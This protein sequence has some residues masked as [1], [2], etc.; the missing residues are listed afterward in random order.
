MTATDVYSGGDRPELGASFDAVA[1]EYDAARPSYPEALFDAVE[2]LAGR[3]LRGADV[4]D[5]GAGTGIAT[6]LLHARGARVTAV[7]PT[8]GMAAQLHSVSPDI[9]LVR[10]N[11]NALPFRDSSA[12]LITYAQAFHWTDWDRSVPEAVRVLRPGGALAV[13]WNVKD[14]AAGWVQAQEARLR[15]A[16]PAY[17]TYGA[18]NAGAPGL[19]RRGLRTSASVLRWERRL[20]VDTALLDLTS[21]SYLAVLTPAER[22]P[23]LAAERAALLEVFPDGTVVEPYVLNLYVGIPQ[24]S[25]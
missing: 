14:R 2:E 13:W 19:R 25:R 10:G 22:E 9:P 11:G 18:V 4:L 1:A 16:C 23:V 8:P 17:H 12:D 15:A 3:P 24:E 6:R 21:R 20:P 5:V 7:E